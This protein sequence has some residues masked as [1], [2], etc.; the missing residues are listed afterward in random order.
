MSGYRLTVRHGPKVRRESFA[1]LDEALEAMREAAQAIRGAGAL[2][3]VKM[4]REFE[5]GGR[6]AGRVELST[7]GFLRGRDAGVDVMGDGRL[8]PYA[9]GMRRRELDGGDPF[10]AIRAELGRN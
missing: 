7:G 9:G 8:V 10:E 5:A 2:E 1:A 3:D 4:L 6:V